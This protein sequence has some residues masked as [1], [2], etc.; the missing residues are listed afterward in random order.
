MA[1]PHDNLILH[2]RYRKGKKPVEKVLDWD[3]AKTIMLVVDVWNEHWCKGA[4]ERLATFMPA[5]VETI[6]AARS[7]GVTILHAPSETMS[8]YNDYPQ[9]QKM[10]AEPVVE[11][12]ENTG[13]GLPFNFPKD[14]T[15]PL[16]VGMDGGCTDT[17]KCRQHNAWTSQHEAV[18]IGPDDLISDKGKEIYSYIRNHGIENV[19][20]LGVHTNMCIMGRPFGIRKLVSWKLNV[21]LCRDLT[22]TMYNPEARPHVPHDRGT[23]LMVEH[24]ERHWCPTILGAELRG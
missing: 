9:R 24:I 23:E 19:I 7:K 18:E 8:F 11:A 15:W 12:K 6:A 5:L 4:N 21:V 10:E 3:P 16:N 14:I 22:D 20:M 13:N 2:A 1:E 17:P